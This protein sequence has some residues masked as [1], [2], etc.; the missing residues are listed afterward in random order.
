MTTLVLLG[1]LLCGFIVD[2]P[3][4]F[5]TASANITSEGMDPI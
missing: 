5:P 2:G 4:P 1:W 3:D